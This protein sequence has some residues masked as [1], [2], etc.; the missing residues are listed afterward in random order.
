MLISACRMEPDG[1]AKGA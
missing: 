1:P